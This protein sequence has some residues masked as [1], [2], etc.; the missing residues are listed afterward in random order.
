[1]RPSRRRSTAWFILKSV[2]RGS[3][4]GEGKSA[5]TPS[6]RRAANGGDGTGLFRPS[7]ARHSQ[8]F[9]IMKTSEIPASKP[10][11]EVRGARPPRAWLDAPSRPAFS[12]CDAFAPS[13]QFLAARVF[14]EGAENSARGGRA[15][16]SISE[17]GLNSSLTVAERPGDGSRGL[18]PTAMDGESSY[19]A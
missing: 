10:N 18:R 1:M 2:L 9:R 11:P 13:A 5:F 17:F 6:R 4:R 19:V 15:P 14:C 16:L 8:P 3:R 7:D 12:A